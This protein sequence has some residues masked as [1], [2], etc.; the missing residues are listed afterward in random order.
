MPPA[1]QQLEQTLRVFG[2]GV[3]Q[4]DADR[5]VLHVR[6][7]STAEATG[8]A[9]TQLSQLV[10][11]VLAALDE[12]QVPRDAI[13]T[14]DV[15]VADRREDPRD[16]VTGRVASSVLRIDVAGLD[17]AGAVLS[18]LASVAGDSLDVQGF[19]MALSDPDSL[20]GEARRRAVHD[21]RTK[22]GEL[23]AAAGVTL[24]DLL[25][26]EEE[27]ARGE[28]PRRLAAAGLALTAAPVPPVPIEGGPLS[29]TSA[30][31]LVYRIS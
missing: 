10:T 29:V 12:E 20:L 11:A 31:T 15:T 8:D 26:I 21:A 24:G 5:C 17:R 1:D 16:R 25:S 14:T 23:A 30:V 7:R 6:L 4:S 28:R 27:P 3:A 13:R 18:R 22:A 19:E 2:T 9:V